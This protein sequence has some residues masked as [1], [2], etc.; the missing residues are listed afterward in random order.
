MN[1]PRGKVAQCADPLQNTDVA[2]AALYPRKLLLL[3]R[4][5][6]ELLVAQQ[7]DA[8]PE[9]KLTSLAR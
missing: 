6:N 3:Q 1:I 2:I 4:R 8:R 5:S 9:S 7:D